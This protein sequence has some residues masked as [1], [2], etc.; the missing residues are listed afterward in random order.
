MPIMVLDF[1]MFA[2][3]LGR[4]VKKNAIYAISLAQVPGSRTT[5][6]PK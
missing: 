4:F 1:F 3:L 6:A 5:R 2:A